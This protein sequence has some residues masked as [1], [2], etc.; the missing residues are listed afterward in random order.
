MNAVV[1]RRRM[2]FEWVASKKG[3]QDGQILPWW[4]VALLLTLFPSRIRWALASSVYDVWSD[5]IK[6]GSARWHMGALERLSRVSAPGHWFRVVGKTETGI[7]TLEYK[8]DGY[9]IPDNAPLNGR[10]TP[11]TVEEV[12]G[13]PKGVGQ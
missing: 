12:V 2:F 10:G 7:V 13:Q 6:V 3:L 1:G 9:T 11:R 8:T 4:A 5:T